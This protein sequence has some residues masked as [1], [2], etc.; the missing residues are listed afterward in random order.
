MQITPGNAN[1]KVVLDSYMGWVIKAA[2]VVIV[3]VALV[4]AWYLI[5]PGKPT[6][7]PSQQAAVDSAVDQVVKDL[8][9]A[10][11][12]LSLVAILSLANDPTSQVTDTLRK[13]AAS[14]GVFVDGSAS[15][16]ENLAD[17][18]R[19]DR[20]TYAELDAA[21]AR[22][23]TLKVDG[24]VFG[25]VQGPVKQ[26]DQTV[27]IINF[28]FAKVGQEAGKEEI[29][30]RRVVTSDT[31]RES[32]QHNSFGTRLLAWVAFTLL[33]PLIA[34]PWVRSLVRRRSNLGNAA[35]LAAMT[36]ASG[37]LAYWMLG[38]A[39]SGVFWAMLFCGAVFIDFV[40]NLAFMNYALKLEH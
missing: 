5:A 24:V 3:I 8:A 36:T 2:M 17:L 37:T 29:L 34:F 33:M 27:V 11:S 28:T 25:S 18:L 35:T 19:M 6:L 1:I 13:R 12:G 7:S 21:A 31:S 15:V 39:V 26:N 4:V 38:G 14:T 10:H 32:P 22:G 40:T 9:A 20:A 30:L 16:S 23:R